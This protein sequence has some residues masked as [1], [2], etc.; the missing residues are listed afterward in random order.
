MSKNIY[1]RQHS[2]EIYSYQVDSL[3]VRAFNEWAKITPLQISR[4]P[5]FPDI[6]IRFEE[7]YHGDSDPFDGYSGVLAHASPPV[8]GGDIHFDN[9][10]IWTHNNPAHYGKKL[11][12]NTCQDSN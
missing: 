3:L 11:Y 6:D 12:Y 1:S 7:R 9:E 5:N 2:S 10:E 8:G 4:T